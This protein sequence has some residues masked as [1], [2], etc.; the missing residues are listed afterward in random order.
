MKT[1]SIKQLHEATGKYVR[2]AGAEPLVVT[3]R[4]SRV[5][6]LRSFSEDDLGGHPFPKRSIRQLP[7]V[8]MDST[9]V[10]SEDRDAR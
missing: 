1:I 10:I 9:S 4:G 5:A 2:E 7:A 8:D 6:V 3:D